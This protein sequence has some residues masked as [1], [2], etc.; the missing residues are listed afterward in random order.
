[1]ARNAIQAQIG[2]SI[3]PT[4]LNAS[5]K[6]V[7]QAL[8]R[9]TGNASEFQKSLDASTARVFAFGATTLVINGVTQSFKALVSTTIE[10]EQRLTDIKA[11]FGGA[12]SQ[13]NTFRDSIFEVARSTG[14]SFATVADGAEEF[15]RQGLSA[16]ETAKRLKA[17]LVLTNISG[18][19][20]VSSVKALTAAINGF[21]SAGLSAEQ[22][23]NKLVAV[24]TKFAVSA[25]DLADGFSR[26]GSTAEDAG[27]SFDELLGLITA[28]QQKTS[29]GGAV[30]GNAFKSI[31]T[32]LNRSTT[33]EELQ[34]LGVAID[35]S[36]SGVQKLQ[37]L[38]NALEGISDPTQASK[39]KELA[40]GVYQINV[41]STALKDLSSEAS[42]FADATGTSSA[43]LNE[44]FEKN[45][46]KMKTVKAQLNAL[47]AG[48]TDLAEKVGQITLVPLLS[49]LVSIADKFGS[50]FREAL[51]P[52]E[53][54][55][56][57]QGFFK[58]IGSF[59]SGPGVV[60]LTTAFIRIVQLVARYAKEGFKSV[61]SIGTETEKLKNIQTGIVNSLVTDKKFREQINDI[62][63]TQ[64]QRQQAILDAI[65]RE[66]I[67]LETKRKLLYDISK[68]AFA[69]G[70]AG[71]DPE[72][73]F[74]GKKGRPIAAKGFAPSFAETV[75]EKS[76]ASAH[77]YKAGNVF[78][79]R[80]YDGTGGSFQATVNSAEKIKTVRGPNGKLG[81]YVIPPN[82]FAANGFVP[83]YAG[84]GK[85]ITQV[86]KMNSSALAQLMGTKKF[87]LTPD[88]DP[89]KA[90]A[91]ARANELKAQG[92]LKAES[93]IKLKGSNYGMLVPSIGFK[94]NFPN[95]SGRVDGLS[96]L[97]DSLAV[98]GIDRS[99]IDKA[100]DPSDELLKSNIYKRVL[101]EG[102]KF[103]N[104]LQGS[105]LNRN[106]M[107]KQI[108]SQDG[109]K[110][111]NAAVGIAFEAATLAAYPSERF[112]Q[113][114][115]AEYNKIGGN[116]DLRNAG[117]T[118]Q[119]LFDLPATAKTLDFKASAGPDAVNN[120]AGK[121]LKEQ[122]FS[123]AQKA[124]V[125]KFANKKGLAASGFVP[126]FVKNSSMMGFGAYGVFHKLNK[127]IGVKRF[128]KQTTFFGKRS[129]EEI[130]RDI[131]E[132]YAISK[133]LSEVPLVRGITGPKIPDTL[134]RALRAK[135]L[136]KQIV[137][138]PIAKQA[139]G[140]HESREFG[141]IMRYLL[142]QKGLEM[143]DLHGENYT[144]NQAGV[145]QI[146]KDDSYLTMMSA[147]ERTDAGSK[148]FFNEFANSGGLATIIDA[149]RAKPSGALKKQYD[150]LKGNFSMQGTDLPSGS[151]LGSVPLKQTSFK[152][153]DSSSA[154]GFVPN[155]S[156]QS[157][158]S[159]YAST[160]TGL[161]STSENQIAAVLE[162]IT[163]S[164]ENWPESGTP[165]NL[166]QTRALNGYINRYRSFTAASRSASILGLARALRE[167][168]LDYLGPS[169]A[170]MARPLASRAPVD[171]QS[172]LNSALEASNPPSSST[173][174]K[175][176]EKSYSDLD[177]V[178]GELKVG[179]LRSKGGNPLFEIAKRIKSREI[180]SIDA[181]PIVG[182]RIPDLIVGLKKMVERLRLKDPSFPRIPIKGYFR[183]KYLTDRINNNSLKKLQSRYP[184]TNFKNDALGV[185]SAGDDFFL[186]QDFRNLSKAYKGLSVK[187]RSNKPIHLEELFPQG[188]AS[189]FIPNFSAIQDAIS[190]EK[191]A[192]IPKS[193]IYI[194]QSPKLK[195][196]RNPSGLMVA[197]RIDEPRGGFQGI[198]RAKM[199]GKNPKSYGAGSGFVP[200][201][202]VSRPL[203]FKVPMS[204]GS[205]SGL[206]GEYSKRKKKTPV[207]ELKRPPALVIPGENSAKKFDIKN[208]FGGFNERLAGVQTALFSLSMVSNSLSDSQSVYNE[209]I[210][211]GILA[212]STFS[213]LSGLGLGKVFS[214]L[215]KVLPF[216][217]NFATIGGVAGGAAATVAG[218]ALL[219]V[220]AGA[221][222]FYYQERKAGKMQD[223]AR[224][225]FEQISLRDAGFNRV[226]VARKEA[227]GKDKGD[228]DSF[229]QSLDG[230]QQGQLRT[231]ESAVEA[232]Y[233][234]AAASGEEVDYS[235]LQVAEAKLREV[236]QNLISSVGGAS[237]AQREFERIRKEGLRG[238]VD[239][240]N[241]YA[242]ALNKAASNLSVKDTALGI[243]GGVSLDPS[244]KN[245]KLLNETVKLAKGTTSSQRSAGDLTKLFA[246]KEFQALAES[247]SNGAGT[248]DFGRIQNSI[249]SP[250]FPSKILKAYSRGGS[251][252]L[253][254]QI[255]AITG[256][257]LD[258][259]SPEGKEFFES[260]VQAA[261]S[262]K[263][264]VVGTYQEAKNGILETNR[265]QIQLAKELVKIAQ[266]KA[267]IEQKAF[268]SLPARLN[269]LAG[270]G[271]VDTFALAKGY[272]EVAQEK[273]P[274]KQGEKLRSLQAQEEKFIQLRGPEAARKLREFSGLN[275]SIT[276]SLRESVALQGVSSGRL[277]SFFK[278]QFLPKDERS[279]VNTGVGSK[280]TME[281]VAKKLEDI[282][283]SFGRGKE[284][285]D[286]AAT[287]AAIIRNDKNV[288]T[289]DSDSEAKKDLDKQLKEG[290][291][292]Q[293]SLNTTISLL[294]AQMKDFTTK[295]SD[296]GL[297]ST[298][299]ILNKS[300]L[301]ASTD[302]SKFQAVASNLGIISDKL[303]TELVK[304]KNDI[305]SLQG[306]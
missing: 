140:S 10:V 156:L 143:T 221:G 62:T 272:R 41:V 112:S 88:S 240:T 148:S 218:G 163:M 80:L 82:G 40:G 195:S 151:G 209:Y 111:I 202:A 203:D 299:D 170:T 5:V 25:K 101:D 132:E 246:G 94:E 142:A 66:N 69:S 261:E 162:K 13:F 85:S 304:I 104:L 43:A 290:A 200:N 185:F 11:I 295:F 181:G 197:N 139:I 45:A 2:V 269:E 109:F 205:F 26:A 73:G 75:A 35:S 23:V 113:A 56:L 16:E 48:F 72:K 150:F 135:S 226:R 120:F 224:T 39:I 105:R 201:Y 271:N 188:L 235:Q 103:G 136:R 213:A 182:P 193:A 129:N 301:A 51:D 127:D 165:L 87:E 55:K 276:E 155:F 31:F 183:P 90:A 107:A 121:M 296:S 78:N 206:P 191:K 128:K 279:F 63:L 239:A 49:T 255:S 289:S 7:R 164:G 64:A 53:G 96:Y 102:A 33:I 153:R 180:R 147:Y 300:M 133:L 24:D 149:G 38:A 198:A 83:N 93:T 8:G 14:Q 204:Y 179:F 280:E 28:V 18:L 114:K 303:N 27:V 9:I 184:N 208:I 97:I 100:A 79:T 212:L 207:S 215:T 234:N 254:S 237:A 137:S 67:L 189:G 306:K 243:A 270:I 263:S 217:K 288:G 86:G 225:E 60:L 167:Q 230:I 52:E 196:T 138:D 61:L 46:E 3:D 192:G 65:T 74:T 171:I 274:I 302:I 157:D 186:P 12:A 249:L 174:R 124:Q 257:N 214:G 294:D 229:F 169:S 176:A 222:A 286:T 173:Y 219:G 44:G 285:K 248:L 71:F 81:T 134:E 287:L 125:T 36:Q 32:R 95:V 131:A 199:E 116:F 267:D 305:A 175:I 231:A 37:A 250:D 91:I 47:V 242:E 123:A 19:D 252:G 236:T 50:F 216:L 144:L 187:S 76:A 282:S 145:N 20:A 110:G 268:D 159:R 277:Q 29:R 284:T 247:A 211:K 118:I 260:V 84:L 293:A 168:G 298:V 59:L 42:I 228:F 256:V 57:I 190:R 244:D 297:I 119:S 130:R 70:V 15:A 161:G 126:N 146:R 178:N 281:K 265:E 1:M 291:E 99:R 283:K 232:V 172:S 77:G 266:Q 166:V 245:T 54:N 158:I 253:E 108:R 264:N 233:K 210:Q 227:F 141:S 117:S 292:K 275:P 92:Q 177:L 4:S 262:F 89:T 223:E 273:D 154:K 58:S 17:A 160:F 34:A 241:R 194:D 258:T 122:A 152:I 259:K 238:L 22:I 278:G 30:I 21:E 68:F 106:I 98:R 115:A 6:E 251:A 220:G